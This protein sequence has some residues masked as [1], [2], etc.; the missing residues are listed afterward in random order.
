[1]RPG[2]RVSIEMSD[3]ELTRL[4]VVGIGDTEFIH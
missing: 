4:W 2:Q 1:M 3:T